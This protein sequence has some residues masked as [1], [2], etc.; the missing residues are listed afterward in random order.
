MEF[1]GEA[2]HV[3]SRITCHGEEGT[4]ITGRRGFKCDILGLGSAIQFMLR[5]SDVPL[6][7]GQFIQ[8][9]PPFTFME[10]QLTRDFH[11]F[12]CCFYLLLLIKIDTVV[13]SALILSEHGFLGFEN[14][15]QSIAGENV[16]GPFAQKM[17]YCAGASRPINTQVVNTMDYVCQ[18]SFLAETTIN[19]KPR[20]PCCCCCC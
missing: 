2:L 6:S 1:T 7:Q 9:Q 20:H 4:F 14:R 3:C 17:A 18:A 19:S 12:T 15:H 11:C 16:R 5:R 13:L 10:T 8:Q